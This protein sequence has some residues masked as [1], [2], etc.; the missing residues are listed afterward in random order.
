M[1]GKIR[2]YKVMIDQLIY[3]WLTKDGQ[4][5]FSGKV[6]AGLQ[7]MEGNPHFTSLAAAV[8]DCQTAYA[9][10]QV[11]RAE[12][13]LGGKERTAARNAARAILVSLLRILFNNINA[14]ANGDEAML[15]STGFIM[16]N[17]SPTPVGKLNPPNPPVLVQ[18]TNSGTMKAYT[19]PVYGAS[20]YTARLALASAPTVH[21]QTTQSTST[22]FEFDELTPGEL[23]NVD[24]NAI[25]SA[26]ASDPSDVSTIRVI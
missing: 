16:R 21:I 7:A 14:L 13:T 23:Y 26:G 1:N 12:A 6:D 11:A 4:A 8:T 10:Y 3:G 22:R 20:L 25:G 24:M 2:K 5:G 18:G 17:T 15:F 9:T 19:S